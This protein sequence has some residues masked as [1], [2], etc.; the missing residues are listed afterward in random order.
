M[1]SNEV[2][3]FYED[4]ENYES[5]FKWMVKFTKRLFA[6]RDLSLMHFFTSHQILCFSMFETYVDWLEKPIVSVDLNWVSAE[7]YKYK[8]SFERR[9]VESDLLRQFIESVHCPFE[10]CLETFD[11]MVEKLKKTSE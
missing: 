9:K 2:I 11:E 6:N 1:T 5:E 7:K 10:K 4:L 3:K 8:I